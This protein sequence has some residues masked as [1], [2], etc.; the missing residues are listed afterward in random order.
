M[1][2]AFL[3]HFLS[4]E[5]EVTVILNGVLKELMRQ[6]SGREPAWFVGDVCVC[7]AGEG[8]AAVLF[9]QPVGFHPLSVSSLFLI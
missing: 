9:Q 3:G 4:Y 7:V 1:L 5:M 8:A 6:M 2:L